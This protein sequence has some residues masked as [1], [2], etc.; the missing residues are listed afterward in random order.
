MTPRLSR[1]QNMSWYDGSFLM[2][3][4]GPL[5]TAMMAQEQASDEAAGQLDDFDISD[6]TK[7]I[8]KKK[9]YKFLFPIQASTSESAF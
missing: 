3:S 1:R 4:C 9:G 2:G 8:L 6:R 7:A 5:L